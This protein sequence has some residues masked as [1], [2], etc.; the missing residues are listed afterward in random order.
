[1]S[2]KGNN[3][4]NKRQQLKKAAIQALYKSRGNISTA[5]TA[6]GI[7]RTTF[8]TWQKEDPEFAEAYSNVTE[9]CIDTVED[10]LKEKIEDG[11]TTAIIFYLKTIGKR[12]GYIE[13]QEL[14]GKDGEALNKPK[15]TKPLID[16]SKLSLDEQVA[17]FNLIKKAKG[18]EEIA[19]VTEVN[20][21]SEKI[22]DI[23]HEEIKGADIK[24]IEQTPPQPEPYI[25]PVNHFDPT[26]KLRET[27]KQVAANKLKNIG[28]NLDDEEKKF[29]NK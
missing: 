27:L 3:K 12:R 1:M 14:T 5:C 6:V 17:L 21:K 19:G 26:I 2:V 15:E 4:D 24:Q 22:E 23:Q 28:A 13:R 20:N 29:L 18:I 11:D 7:N 10:K 9:Y 25:S 16:V 8:Y